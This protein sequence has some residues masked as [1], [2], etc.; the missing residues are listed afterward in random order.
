MKTTTSATSP[1]QKLAAKLAAVPFCQHKLG[2]EIKRL[3]NSFYVSSSTSSI[4]E[5]ISRS[6]EKS[7]FYGAVVWTGRI[8]GGR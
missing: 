3:S 6:V 1:L 7:A 8:P 5:W 2:K 4:G